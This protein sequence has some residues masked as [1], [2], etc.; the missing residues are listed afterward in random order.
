MGSVSLKNR[1][2]H[3]HII[4]KVKLDWLQAA[5]RDLWKSVKFI[6]KLVFVE[7]GILYVT[8]SISVCYGSLLRSGMST[9]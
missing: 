2:F 3:F 1:A 9:Q 7:A 8:A 6:R 5:R 4:C